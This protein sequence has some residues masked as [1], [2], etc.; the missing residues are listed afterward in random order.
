M[1]KQ[2][3]D[4]PVQPAVRKVRGFTL[5]ELLIAVAI[6]GIIAAV[7]IP[8]YSGYVTQ[9]RRTEAIS[10]LLEASGEQVR[11][12][13]ENNTYA[14]SMTQMGYGSDNEPSENGHYTIAVVSTSGAQ[15]KLTATPIGNQL[16]DTE[17]ASLSIDSSG[18]KEESGSGTREDCW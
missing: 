17:C 18:L 5:I 14:T 7:A 8:S 16:D 3:D 13:T 10:L 15:Y 12:F 2:F 6:I 1:M 4:N 11:F 9:S